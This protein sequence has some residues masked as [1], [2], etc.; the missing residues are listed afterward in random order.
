MQNLDHSSPFPQ[1]LDTCSDPK[2]PYWES[3]WGEFLNRYKD[4][5]YRYIIKRCSTWNAPRLRRQFSDTVNDAVA[6]VFIILTKNNCQALK[7]FRER[8]NEIKFLSWLSILCGRAAGRYMRKNFLPQVL[9]SEIEEIRE[10][11]NAIDPDE[12]W[13]L[14]ETIISALRRTSQKE[15][16]INIF[17]TYTWADYNQEMIST[18]P[19]FQN[20]GHRVVDNVVNR[21]RSILR[22]TEEI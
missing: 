1:L 15:R 3:A 5:I 14:Y 4:N 8:D 18:L 19:C 13:E 9:D 2:S 7:D 22:D 20:M 16:D 11:L 10:S 17:L 21:L 12:R 6:D